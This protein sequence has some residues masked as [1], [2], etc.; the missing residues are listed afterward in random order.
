M[1]IRRAVIDAL[2]AAHAGWDRIGYLHHIYVMHTSP[3]WSVL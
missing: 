2:V 3:K 1:N